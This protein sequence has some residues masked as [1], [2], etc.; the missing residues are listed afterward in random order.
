MFNAAPAY[1][2]YVVDLAD[3]DDAE[4]D[5]LVQRFVGGAWHRTLPGWDLELSCGLPLPVRDIALTR[6][7]Q[8][9]LTEGVLC[10]DC[11]TPHEINRARLNDLADAER[12]TRENDERNRKMD[13][14]FSDLRSAR[15]PKGDR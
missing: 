14:F 11:F 5:V 2:T 15:K 13:Q 9:S 4:E 10:G 8:L 1:E 6:R 12:V 3:I 7:E